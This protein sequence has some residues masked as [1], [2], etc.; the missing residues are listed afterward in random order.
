MASPL[1]SPGV[2]TREIDVSGPTAI[3]PQGVPAGV[4]GTAQKGRAFV[5]ITFATY[6]DFVAEF[7]SSDGEKFGPLAVN[8]WMK[9]ARAGSYVR[10]LGI[11]DGKRRQEAGDNAGRVNNAGFVVGSSLVQDNGFVGSNPHANSDVI[12]ETLITSPTVG[13]VDLVKKLTFLGV[14]AAGTAVTFKK[15]NNA[16]STLT[17]VEGGAGAGEISIDSLTS[18][19]DA[20]TQ[21]KS[22]ID[23]DLVG[24]FTAVRVN[25]VVTI[26]GICDVGLTLPTISVAEPAPAPGRTHFLASFMRATSTGSA[27]IL[28]DALGNDTITTDQGFPILRGVIFAASGV[29]LSL[30][31]NAL[32]NNTPNPSLRAFFDF[33]ATRDVGASHGS[34]NTTDGM[35]TFMMILNGHKPSDLHSNVITASFDPTA[36]DYF[37]NVFNTDPYKIEEA[38]HLLYAHYDVY[39][40]IAVPGAAYGSGENSATLDED[41]SAVNNVD[42]VTELTFNRI[43]SAGTTVTLTDNAGNDE[44]ITFVA[45]A[46]VGNQITLVGIA[47]A[48]G[49]AGALRNKINTLPALADL[50]SAGG[51]GVVVAATGQSSTG[52]VLPEVVLGGVAAASAVTLAVDTA[53]S[54]GQDLEATIDFSGVPVHGTSFS[55]VN[56]DNSTQTITFVEGAAGPNEIEIGG[57]ADADAAAAA[58][59]TAINALLGGFFTSV[60]DGGDDSIVLV[61]GD[62]TPA[63]GTEP[64]I[65]LVEPDS[66]S[67]EVTTEPVAGVNLSSVVTF[68]SIPYPGD[69]FTLTPK[70]GGDPV[71]ITFVNG[72]AGAN[73]IDISGMVSTDDAANDLSAKIN[74]IPALDTYFVAA[75]VGNVVTI[76]GYVGSDSESFPTVVFTPLVNDAALLLHGTSDWNM[77]DGLL[78]NYEN[79]EE[80]FQTA[81]SPWFISQKFGGK[82]KKLFK[83]HSLDDGASGNQLFKITIENIAASNNLN[84]KYGTFDLLVRSIDD[85]DIDPVVLESFRGLTLDPSSERFVAKVIGDRHVFYDLDQLTG[86]QKLRIEG[87]YANASRHIRLE[88]DPQVSRQ[89][90]NPEC[91]P[92]GFEGFAHTNTAGRIEVD[93]SSLLT[94]YV[95]NL[96]GLGT[97]DF[98][99]V[100]EPP[101]PMRASIAQGTGLTKKLNSKLTWGVQFE[102]QS[103]P[104]NLNSNAVINKSMVSFAK[105]FPSFQTGLNFS[106]VDTSGLP[107]LGDGIV[108][109]VDSF[110]KNKFSLENVQ[111]VT[112]STNRPAPTLWGAAVYR[113]DGVL[114]DELVG[115]DGTVYPS[116]VTRFLDPA[117]DLKDLS[118]RQFAKFTCMVQGGFDGYN[119]FD[120]QKSKMTDIAVRREF[121]DELNQGGVYGPTIAAFRKAVDVL[122]EKTD[123]D[124]QLLSIPGMRH[125]SITDYAIDAVESR[126]D[127]MYI[128]DIEE[129]DQENIFMTGSSTQLPSVSYTVDNFKSR[130]LDTSFAAAYYP[131]VT[132]IDPNTRTTVQ[133]PPSVPVLGAFS[134]NDSIAYPWFAPA[135]FTRGALASVIETQV[136]LSRPNMDTLYDANINPI[137]SFA[138]SNGVVVFGQKTLQT[139]QTALDRVNVR[140]L[141]IEIRRRVRRIA[142]TFI[143][144][145]NRAETLAR[146]SSLITP[147]LQQIQAQNGVDRFRV[148]IDTTTTTQADVENNTLRG[149]IYIQPT[150]AVEFI[151]IDFVV[152]NQGALI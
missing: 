27:E 98:A 7:G 13:G 14:P 6:Q 33:G 87:S 60:I 137:T 118:T 111:I 1:K 79:F 32:E 80:R 4:I 102:V 132:V 139:A 66:I 128:M 22:K 38:G 124:I 86:R 69:S 90:A 123:V 130:N 74:S 138:D 50:F 34:V 58:L 25:A 141:L 57:L 44:V 64:S 28:N 43:P 20:A 36:A 53:P 59:N 112:G 108:V 76:T 142:N 82:N 11:G 5:P 145:P 37:P 39:P 61:T 122:S 95:A 40:S 121:D 55:F 152:T 94:G 46:A 45:G 134:L 31:T 117:N 77:P 104:N 85:T 116:N 127:A 42:L 15:K 72:G 106:S 149:K 23:A 136:K 49:A 103:N 62:N 131:D 9:N 110:N 2:S 70:D 48:A 47:D 35:Q 101:V 140:R 8:E 114:A 30:S 83:V 75:A 129:K 143:F 151:S 17:F 88:M 146:F 148:Q 126:F 113:R 97:A 21:L 133:V 99:K 147:V 125:P 65:T 93:E 12:V 92:I 51:A 29:N 100:K 68:A 24:F 10:V 63:G 67:A 81:R 26:T 78:P 91:L 115:T 73:D 107:D 89:S 54:A 150:R 3:A 56:G 19:I 84:Y 18:A 41:I 144:E 105:F 119:I 52:G 120:K 71:V 96:S 135:G 16:T 109:D